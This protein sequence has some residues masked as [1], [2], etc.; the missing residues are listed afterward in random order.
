MVYWLDEA[1]IQVEVGTTRENYYETYNKQGDAR[2]AHSPVR[3]N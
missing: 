1:I 2:T 3:E